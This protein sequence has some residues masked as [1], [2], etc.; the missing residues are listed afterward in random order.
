MRAFLVGV[1]L[2]VDTICFGWDVRIMT[3]NVENLGERKKEGRENLRS[4][5]NDA[6]RALV[7]KETR[8]AR[9]LKRELPDLLVLEEVHD[10][11]AL[12]KIVQD[13]HWNQAVKVT[14]SKGPL[15]KTCIVGPDMALRTVEEIPVRVVEFNGSHKELRSIIASRWRF[16]KAPVDV[17]LLGAHLPAAYHSVAM[18][19]EAMIKLTQEARKRSAEK[20]LLVAAGDFNTPRK[21]EDAVHLPSY[22]QLASKEL[23]Q[24][25]GTY[26]HA[27][28]W[29]F[30]DNVLLYKGQKHSFAEVRVVSHLPFQKLPSGAPARFDPIRLEGVSDHFPLL[31]KIHV[32]E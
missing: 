11:K 6:R 29:H 21:D 5:Q 9:I 19:R 16:E 30:L 32:P 23:P 12:E 27:K 7:V 24:N 14:C 13:V 10:V 26:F 25:S 22:W 20:V 2:F 3:M 8:I 1:W 4:A 17:M 15:Q 31:V 28:A 18:R